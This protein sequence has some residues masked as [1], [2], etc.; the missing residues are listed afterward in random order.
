MNVLISGVCHT[1]REETVWR[2]DVNLFCFFCRSCSL[3]ISGSRSSRSSCG[4]E[5][6]QGEQTPQ[7][8]QTTNPTNPGSPWAG[9][10]AKQTGWRGWFQQAAGDTTSAALS[11]L[12]WVSPCDTCRPTQL[13]NFDPRHPALLLHFLDISHTHTPSYQET[14]IKYVDVPLKSK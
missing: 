12:F 3:C 5:L 6:V 13:Q 4:P 7:T 10:S 8:P 9:G 14:G 2:S 1:N 11:F